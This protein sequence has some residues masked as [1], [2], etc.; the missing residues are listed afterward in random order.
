V[1]TISPTFHLITICPDM[2]HY[3]SVPGQYPREVPYSAP[4]T[5]RWQGN[6]SPMSPPPYPGNYEEFTTT[7]LEP[8]MA[9]HTTTPEQYTRPHLEA[10][11]Q[12]PFEQPTS[13]SLHHKHLDLPIVIPQTSPGAGNPFTRAYSPSLSTTNI[14]LP[15]FLTFLDTLNVCFAQTPPL[16]ILDLAGGVVG[17]VPHHIPALIGGSLQ[18]TA[19][20]ANAVTSKA[21]VAS[22]LKT[23]NEEIFAPQGLKVEILDT[24]T[25]KGRLGID[26]SRPLLE[27]LEEEDMEVSVRDRRLQALKPHVAPLVFDVPVPARQTNAIDRLAAGQLKRQMAKAEEKAMEARRKESEKADKKAKKEERK[28]EKDRKRGKDEKK[29]KGKDDKESKAAEKLLWVFIGRL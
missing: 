6:L 28:A 14:S 1:S 24:E 12:P 25:L 8:K 27:D 4:P 17:M 18:A 13:H 16:Q 29:R 23:A 15:T 3:Y 9:Y 7:P 5:G 21:R 26:A 2:A 22:L 11:Y 19:K 10:S 20:I